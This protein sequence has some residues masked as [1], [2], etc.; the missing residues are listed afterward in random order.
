MVN[1]QKSFFLFSAIAALLLTACGAGVKSIPDEPSAAIQTIADEMRADNWSILWHAMPPSYQ[2]DVNDIVQLAGTKVDADIY[3]ESISFLGRLAEVADKQKAYII[4]AELSGALPAEELAEIEAA[5]PSIIG[6]VES[7]AASSI[8]SSAGLQAFDG[9][10]FFKKTFPD[11]VKYFK[12]L[13]MLYG[14]EALTEFYAE[15]EFDSV[16]T[17]AST[18]TTAV[19]E[20][21]SINGDVETDDLVKVENRWVPTDLA[22]IWS[23][24]MAENKEELEAIPFD[25]LV[26][27]KSQIMSAFTMADALLTQLDSAQTQEEFDQALENGMMP[28][29]LLIAQAMG[30]F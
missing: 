15:L 26:Q 5:W 22:T 9:D 20:I 27:N 8:S 6:F 28:I 13:A 1:I 7:I 18:D 30:E 24:I 10:V 23:E 12:D 17:V 16:K 11:L 19:L 21:T 2:A 25:N 14:D 29:F 3:D 4:N